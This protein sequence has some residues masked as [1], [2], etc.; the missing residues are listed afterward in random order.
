VRRID[1]VPQW[2]TQSIYSKQQPPCQ[3]PASFESPCWEAC[4]TESLGPRFAKELRG[5]GT[6]EEVRRSADRAQIELTDRGVAHRLLDH[7]FMKGH[8]ATGSKTTAMVK[9]A[10]KRKV[11]ACGKSVGLVQGIARMSEEGH[12]DVL[13]HVA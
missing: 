4:S 3:M 8:R 6:T 1:A 7:A 9:E 12:V 13:F 2:G 11:L 10:T 5:D